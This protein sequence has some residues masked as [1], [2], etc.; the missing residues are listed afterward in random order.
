MS[1]A[2][3]ITQKDKVETWEKIAEDFPSCALNWRQPAAD[4]EY[5]FVVTFCVSPSC[6]SSFWRLGMAT[7]RSSAAAARHSRCHSC[8]LW[9]KPSSRHST[10]T[11]AWERG[12]LSA[13]TCPRLGYRWEHTPNSWLYT[14]WTTILHVCSCLLHLPFDVDLNIQTCDFNR[15]K[16]MGCLFCYSYVIWW[17]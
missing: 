3:L 13:S 10:Q 11:S 15:G 14:C 5:I 6:Q 4:S 17:L 9:R 16:K 8:R 7:S 2:P 1:A 12:W